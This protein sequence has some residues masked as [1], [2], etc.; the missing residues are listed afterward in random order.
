MTAFFL[1]KRIENSPSFLHAE[2]RLILEKTAKTY[3]ERG[4]GN[5]LLAKCNPLHHRDMGLR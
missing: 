1:K 4:L 3:L 2:S 5:G